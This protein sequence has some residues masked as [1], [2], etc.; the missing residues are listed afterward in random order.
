MNC[1]PGPSSTEVG[2]DA[3]PVQQHRDFGLSFSVLDEYLVHPTNDSDFLIRAGNQDHPVG[4]NALV[5]T[6]F[7]DGLLLTCLINEHPS[8]AKAC[9]T[10]LLVAAPYQIAGS[11]EHLSRKFTAIFARHRALH[12]LDDCGCWTAV[13]LELF[14]A[15]MHRNPG[16]AAEVL[17]VPTFINILESTPPTDIV[18]KYGRK[19]DLTIQHIL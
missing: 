9:G 5:L 19:V 2:Q 12:D 10:A 1:S 18:H 16:S 11:V 4:L 15:I 7:Q 8:Q 6:H 14:G 3:L 17:I 13:V